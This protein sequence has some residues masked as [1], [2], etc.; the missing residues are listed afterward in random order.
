[1]NYKREIKISDFGKG[2]NEVKVERKISK[3]ETISFQI[4]RNEQE[5]REICKEIVQKRREINLIFEDKFRTKIFKPNEI[6]IWDI[7]Q[8]CANEDGFNNRIQEITTLIAGIETKEIEEKIETKNLEGSINLLEAFLKLKVPGYDKRTIEILRNINSLRS[9]KYPIHTDTIEFLKALR[10]F[11]IK[12]FPPDWGELW[13]KI[14]KKYLWAL[15]KLKDNLE[16]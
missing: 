15:N 1:M 9:K 14:L 4:L 16:K 5:V 10:Y 7:Q 11:G 3:E 12:T 2:I 6:A 13:E 8:L